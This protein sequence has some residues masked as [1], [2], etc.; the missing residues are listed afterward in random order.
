MPSSLHSKPV[1]RQRS[2]SVQKTI[3][4]HGLPPPPPR[5]VLG[6]AVCRVASVFVLMLTGMVVVDAEAPTI[7]RHSP[8][9]LDVSGV[10]ARVVDGAL[11]ELDAIGE[12]RQASLAIQCSQHLTREGRRPLALES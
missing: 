3:Q 1:R 11:A 8:Q 4:L 12:I 9:L 7:E 2:S 6:T 5:L 10:L